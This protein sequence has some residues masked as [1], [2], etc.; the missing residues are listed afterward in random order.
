MTSAIYESLEFTPDHT[1][2][3]NILETRPESLDETTSDYEW[4]KLCERS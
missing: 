3:V 1:S 4:H 2:I